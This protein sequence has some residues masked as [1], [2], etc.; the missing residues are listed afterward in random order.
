MSTFRGLGPFPGPSGWAS[1]VGVSAFVD[2]SPRDRSPGTTRTGS[3]LPRLSSGTP[4]P[5]PPPPPSPPRPPRPPAPPEL[6]S[7][8]IRAVP[9]QNWTAG[10]GTGRGLGG[11]AREGAGRG[12][13]RGGTRAGEKWQAGA[14]AG[15]HPGGVAGRQLRRGLEPD[16]PPALSLRPPVPAVPAWGMNGKEGRPRP[17]TPAR[18]RGGRA[19]VWARRSGYGRH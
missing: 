12:R 4:V 11:R 16:A 3:P 2:A 8:G 19:W 15:R 17:E 9:T 1:D 10:A 18:T 13:I 7:G 6:T 14:G 5:P